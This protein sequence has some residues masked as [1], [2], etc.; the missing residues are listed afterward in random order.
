MRKVI[1]GTAV[2]I[3]MLFGDRTLTP[4]V[5]GIIEGAAQID[6]R[7]QTGQELGSKARKLTIDLFAKSDR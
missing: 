7:R 5:V 4:W 6:L 2:L 1:V 3:A